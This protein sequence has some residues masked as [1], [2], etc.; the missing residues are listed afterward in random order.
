MREQFLQDDR[1]ESF[2]RKLSN[3]VAG[4]AEPPHPS[5]ATPGSAPATTPSYAHDTHHSGFSGQIDTNPYL[6]QNNGA[7]GSST[8]ESYSPYTAPQ[9]YA[10]AQ[11]SQESQL[12]ATTPLP[13]YD[14][15]TASSQYDAYHSQF[16]GANEASDTPTS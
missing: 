5:A 15:V 16:E 4:P 13:G 12:D 10:P 11:I 9:T 14:E 2:E 7:I 8:P 6:T 3:W 1:E